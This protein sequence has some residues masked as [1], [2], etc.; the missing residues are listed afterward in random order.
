MKPNEVYAKEL[1]EIE[2]VLKKFKVILN[3][4]VWWWWWYMMQL[5]F[6]YLNWN[7]E[8]EVKCVFVFEVLFVRENEKWVFL[9][10][11]F[12]LSF[13]GCLSILSSPIKQTMKWRTE[14]IAFL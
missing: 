10:L 2:C 14:N 3:Y 5:I 4:I 11:S 9:L 13:N 8:V 1:R 12:L 6:I 7:D